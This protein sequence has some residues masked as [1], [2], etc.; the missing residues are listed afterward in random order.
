MSLYISIYSFHN[1]SKLSSFVSMASHYFP[2]KKNHSTK[3]FNKY[4]E[5][6]II[7]HG[8]WCRFLTLQMFNICYGNSKSILHI[9][10]M[11]SLHIIYYFVESF[12]QLI[13]LIIVPWLIIKLR[14]NYVVTHIMF[15]PCFWIYSNIFKWFRFN[16]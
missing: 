16:Y 6:I 3:R 2:C 13:C 8:L 10:M 15:S 12:S 9:H 1:L 5:S 4:N 14:K 7:W 11:W